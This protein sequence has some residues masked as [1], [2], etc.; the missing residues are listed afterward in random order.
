MPHEPW[1][2]S[3]WLA[4]AFLDRCDDVVCLS[5]ATLNELR[6]LMPNRVAIMARQGFHPVY[7]QYL[8]GNEAIVAREPLTLLFF[9]L[10]KK[11][12]GLD[13]L[14]KA[15]PLVLKSVPDARLLIAGEIY[16][17]DAT[18]I[19]MIRELGIATNVEAHFSFVPD[20]EV[21]GWFQRASLCVLPYRSASQSG[22]IALSYAFGLPVLASRLEGLAQYV[23]EGKT[24]LLV[25]ADPEPR[26]EELAS[27]IVSYLTGDQYPRMHRFVI[28]K[29][30][31]FS[32]SRL[33]DIVIKRSIQ[34]ET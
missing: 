20:S 5:T 34:A 31:E 19:E 33:G 16:G 13:I 4:K 21:A 29:A 7:N 30:A 26:P 15:M 23:E 24:G 17:S 12:K 9:G 3:R 10:I 28:E 18:Y 6:A 11:Y 27:E 2:G 22:I 32:W 8:R 1:I 14:L 25:K